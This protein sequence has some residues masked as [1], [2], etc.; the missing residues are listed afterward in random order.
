VEGVAGGAGGAGG[1][2]GEDSKGKGLFCISP[3][4]QR[5]Y[6]ILLTIL[7][8]ELLHLS[9]SELPPVVCHNVRLSEI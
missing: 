6:L 9:G 8:Q 1:R 7:L 4:H 2:A 3:F 5:V